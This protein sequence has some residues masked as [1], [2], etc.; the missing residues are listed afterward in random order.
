MTF[1]DFAVRL[2]L[3]LELQCKQWWAVYTDSLDLDL[4]FLQA[5]EKAEYDG[6]IRYINRLISILALEIWYQIFISKTMNPQ[7]KLV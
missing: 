1:G 4:L 7:K 6:D 2:S 5:F 3:S